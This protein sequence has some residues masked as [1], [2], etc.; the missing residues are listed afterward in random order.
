M[1]EDNNEFSQEELRHALLKH[2]IHIVMQDTACILPVL[3]FAWWRGNIFYGVIYVTTYAFLRIHSGGWHAPTPIGCILLY[4]SQYMIVDM[5]INTGWFLS[6]L[7]IL[8]LCSK[9]LYDQMPF[10]HQY[11]PLI[12]KELQKNKKTAR[13]LVL[14]YLISY[15]ISYSFLPK[16][17]NCFFFVLAYTALLGMCQ[18]HSIYNLRNEES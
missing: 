18:R 2:G 12:K 8:L 11:Q 9:Y 14:I 13:V 6:K 7:F 3:V 15:V 16:L 4:I 5:C 17:A 10:Q 1:N